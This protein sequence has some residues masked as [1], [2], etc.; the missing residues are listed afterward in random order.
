MFG[1]STV[2]LLIPGQP[3]KDS[4]IW[5]PWGSRLKELGHP[6][7][8]SPNSVLLWIKKF[9]QWLWW[10]W[11]HCE[12]TCSPA[13]GTQLVAVW[14]QTHHISQ[15]ILLLCC[16]TTTLPHEVCADDLR[17]SVGV[18]GMVKQ[19]LNYINNGCVWSFNETLGYTDQT[20]RKSESAITKTPLSWTSSSSFLDVFPSS[21][22][23]STFLSLHTFGRHS[24][25][26]SA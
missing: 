5:Q 12:D 14:V 23:C 16:C 11:G 26:E 20:W 24:K 2:W 7:S 1:C 17:M 22:Y 15:L 8:H 13:N 18:S 4:Q 3:Y 21:G 25:P 10:L 19:L 9:Q 6:T